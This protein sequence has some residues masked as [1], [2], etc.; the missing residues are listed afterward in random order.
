MS[1]KLSK[2]ISIDLAGADIR[3]VTSI[4][5]TKGDL[6]IV[7]DEN[8]SGDVYISLSDV[9]LLDA[10]DFILG[11]QGFS[12]KIS[13]DTMLIGSQEFLNKASNLET[14]VIRLNNANPK[15]IIPILSQYI[16][17]K[18][19]IQFQEKLLIITASRSNL[20]QISKLVKKLD[21]EKTPQIILEAQILEVSQAAL[22]NIVVNWAAHMKLVFKIVNQMILILIQQGYCH[23]LYLERLNMRAKL[24]LAKPRIKAIHGEPVE[25]FIGDQIPFT[26]VTVGTAGTV[27]ESVFINSGINL[28]FFPEVNVY[29]QEIK[30]KIQPEVSY[31][32]DYVGSKNKLPVVRTRRVDTTVFVKNGNTVLIEAYLTSTDSETISRVPILGHMPLIGT[33]FTRNKTDKDQKELVIAITPQIIN[34]EF[35]ESIPLPLLKKSS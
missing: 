11:S 3:D 10:I 22:D 5:A 24:I 8:L 21:A 12:Y 26:E 7:T 32:N 29:T 6:N 13:N 25:I 30:I 14:K 2:L 35:K 15:T 4:L 23:I 18:E 19:N 34:E 27:S 9:S 17:G 1:D 20:D 33:F 28:S 16:S 31:V